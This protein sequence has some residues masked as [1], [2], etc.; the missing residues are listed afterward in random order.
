MSHSVNG[1]GG[2]HNGL[3]ETFSLLKKRVKLF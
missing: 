2:V 3:S 1:G